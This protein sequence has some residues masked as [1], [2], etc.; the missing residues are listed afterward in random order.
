MVASEGAGRARLNP[1][2]RRQLLAAGAAAGVAAIFKTPLT[3]VVYAIE[4]PYVDDLG[5]RML[6]P[7]LVGAATGYTV[8][9][10]LLGTDPLFRVSGDPQLRLLD[11]ALAVVLGAVCGFGA[12]AYAWLL[13]TAKDASSRF[14]VVP[15]VLVGGAVLAACTALSIWLFDA[16]LS[17]GPGYLALDWMADPD[18]ALWLLVALLLL[19]IVASSATL[20][21]GGVGGL[22]IPLVVAAR[23]PAG[24]WAVS[25]TAWTPRSTPS[26]AWRRSSA[27]ATRC[28]WPRWSS[29]P[30][31]A[32]ARPTSCQGSSPPWW[33]TWWPAAPR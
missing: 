31:S 24:W 11:L 1:A 28:R 9:G 12:K 16:P 29:W 8:C 22:F 10:V 2:E 26:S 32:A 3:A 23:S 17:L 14:P 6:L 15:R 19:R 18:R 4:V 27:R 13:R 7:A 5:R 30:R 25:T 20:G 33:P 21:A